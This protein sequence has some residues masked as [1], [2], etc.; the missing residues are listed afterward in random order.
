MG[1][2]WYMH[3]QGYIVGCFFGKYRHQ[4]RDIMSFYLGR[5]LRSTE[6]VHHINGNKMDNR[7]ENLEI[8]NRSIHAAHH[9]D[10]YNMS[11]A[12]NAARYKK[13]YTWRNTDAT[14]RIRV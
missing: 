8:V 11:R 14:V 4:H 7:I 6:I 10:S 2:G 13:S 12:G 9:F 3:S 1:K 5:P